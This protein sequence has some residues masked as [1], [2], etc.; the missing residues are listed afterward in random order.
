M[1]ISETGKFLGLVKTKPEFESKFDKED[2]GLSESDRA[3]LSRFAQTPEVQ[4]VQDLVMGQI[5]TSWVGSWV[6]R[7]TEPNQSST[8]T[9]MG[10]WGIGQQAVKTTVVFKNLGYLPKTENQLHLRLEETAEGPDLAKAVSDTFGRLS[11]A[12]TA[13]IEENRKPAS[14]GALLSSTDLPAIDPT[15]PVPVTVDISA[16]RQQLVVDVY[17]DPADLRPSWVRRCV[18]RPWILLVSA[19]KLRQSP[20]NTVSFGRNRDHTKSYVRIGVGQRHPS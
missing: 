3:S 12:K 11:N 5:W 1:R 17:T 19:V 18:R 13:A 20:T 7:R 8:N 14:S 10:N 6:D 15:Q 2:S 9:L 16:A 4:R